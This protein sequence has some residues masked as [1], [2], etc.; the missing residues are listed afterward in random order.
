VS[1]LFTTLV[2]V[3]APPA[4]RADIERDLGEF[5]ANAQASG[6]VCVVGVETT[7]AG[8]MFIV[9]MYDDGLQLSP[10]PA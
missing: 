7:S 8:D 4:E 6:L 5:V 1:E 3:D 9:R 10:E 2:P